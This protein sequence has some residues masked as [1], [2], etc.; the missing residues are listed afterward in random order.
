MKCSNCGTSIYSGANFCP[1]CGAA[2]QR[3]L[4][5]SPYVY[6]QPEGVCNPAPIVDQ[7]YAKKAKRR[8][9][10]DLVLGWVFTG[11]SLIMVIGLPG[12]GLKIAYLAAAAL[13]CPLASCRS[14][15]ERLRIRR[16]MAWVLA[17]VLFYGA[18]ALSG[19]L[20]EASET[21]D[22]GPSRTVMAA[23]EAPTPTARPTATPRPTNTPR[24]TPSPSPV[25]TEAPEP[26]PTP[27]KIWGFYPDTTVFVSNSGKIHLDSDCSGMKN[28]TTMTLESAYNA[29]Y[30]KCERCW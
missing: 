18:T 17:L 4:I 9:I 8:R 7:S 12:A 28:Y 22:S 23:I 13:F 2:V 25:P 3:S 29:G 26:T 11:V 10:V 20:P 21:A 15:L 5:R 19:P 1:C 14:L 16:W 30:E 27:Y 6:T 24:P